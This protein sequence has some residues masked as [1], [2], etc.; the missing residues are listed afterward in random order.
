M[1]FLS[2]CS[3][4]QPEKGMRKRLLRGGSLSSKMPSSFAIPPNPMN[5][6]LTSSGPPLHPSP[7]IVSMT[8]IL[9]SPSIS[10]AAGIQWVLWKH[11]MNGWRGEWGFK[12]ELRN[13]GGT[14]WW[15]HQGPGPGSLVVWGGKRDWRKGRA[16]MW[17]GGEPHEEFLAS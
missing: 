16:R 15:R 6:L 10:A 12:A 5:P 17:A 13:S 14:P 8:A 7:G 3:R 4:T 9:V 2:G 11:W 1:G